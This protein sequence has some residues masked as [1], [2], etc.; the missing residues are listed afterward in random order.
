MEKDIE[1]KVDVNSK[2]YQDFIS[3]LD[4]VNGQIVKLN[5]ELAKI[6]DVKTMNELGA[7]LKGLLN[8][9]KY[10][11]RDDKDTIARVLNK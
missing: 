3:A 1:V 6:T 11:C 2:E 9:R 5:E 10:I 7:I 8:D 4:I